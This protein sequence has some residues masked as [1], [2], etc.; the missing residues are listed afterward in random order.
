MKKAADSR[1]SESE[2]R[3]ADPRWGQPEAW[4]GL[5]PYVVAGRLLGGRFGIYLALAL[6][7]GGF[8]QDPRG[9]LPALVA[10]LALATILGAEQ[11]GG[12][13][14]PPA[15]G[16]MLRYAG[17]I[18]THLAVLLPL[19]LWTCLVGQVGDRGIGLLLELG[20][21]VGNTEAL[22]HH[23]LCLETLPWGFLGT[24]S[25]LAAYPAYLL[26]QLA[27]VEDLGPREVLATSLRWPEE[28]PGDLLGFLGAWTLLL[29][30]A[31]VGV[32]R[33]R[34]PPG[35]TATLW[36]LSLLWLVLAQLARLHHQQAGAPDPCEGIG[37]LRQA[38]WAG[39]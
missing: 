12:R 13:S 29:L 11:L 10:G 37:G 6:A 25:L 8:S 32:V 23:L 39:R 1:S 21:A 4:G 30:L 33:L 24:P 26:T 9:Y 38:S 28:G 19:Y 20:R 31:A 27:L 3:A 36:H 14:L 35:P 2:V 15:P 7:L 16:T 17:R 18:P 22:Q 5:V 34:L